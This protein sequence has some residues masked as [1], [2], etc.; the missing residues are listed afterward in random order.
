LVG[1]CGFCGG[2]VGV[3]LCGGGGFFLFGLFGLVLLSG[4]ARCKGLR[5]ADLTA[6]PA[7]LMSET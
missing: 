1:A 3:C 5:S 7:S 4:K 6:F 2:F